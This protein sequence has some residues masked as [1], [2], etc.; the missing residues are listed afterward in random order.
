MQELS[1]A[2][3]MEQ[4]ASGDPKLQ[5]PA[6]QKLIDLKATSA[7]PVIL[8]MLKSS[9][10][11]VRFCAAE[12]LGY[13]GEAEIESV[14]SALTNLLADP[15]GLVRAEA[16][17]SLGILGY[18][19]ARN[20][21]Q[22]LLLHDPDPLV[23]ASAAETLGDLGDCHALEALKLAMEDF[24]QAVRSYSANSLG[25]L[26]T[27]ELLPLLQAYLESE[28]SLEVKA[29]L[30]V[31]QY[32][33]GKTAAI[34]QLLSLLAD[35]DEDLATVILNVLTDLIERRLP[36]TIFTDAPNIDQVLT[37]VAQ[38]FSLLTRHA[39]SLATKLTALRAE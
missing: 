36:S 15:E 37:S 3:L 2:A 7:V 12:A 23:R 29:E 18:R 13:L 26:G 27:P 17:D 14:G 20:P 9:D 28:E 1:I 4:C 22:S 38:R 6:L 11:M 25:L 8:E 30:L 35:A 39:Q 34:T 16:V 31:A 33:L 32:R 21:V 24:D 19:S 5:A 10:D